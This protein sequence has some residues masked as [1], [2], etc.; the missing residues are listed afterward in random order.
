M[1]WEFK[2]GNIGIW[3]RTYMARVDQHLIC[4]VCLTCVRSLYLPIWITHN[5][6]KW[7]PYLKCFA[8]NLCTMIQ[9]HPNT[10]FYDWSAHLYF[11]NNAQ[12][13]FI[14]SQLAPISW[15][16]VQKSCLSKIENCFTLLYSIQNSYLH[17]WDNSQ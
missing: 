1:I 4:P 10:Q 12:L 17:T 14:D 11:T 8:I 16:L 2:V 7:P 6:P 13:D 15:I 9:I 3:I 5:S